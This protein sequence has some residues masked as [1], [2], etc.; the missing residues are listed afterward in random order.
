MHTCN[1]ATVCVS[2][3]LTDWE[4]SAEEMP[5]QSTLHLGCMICLWYKEKMILIEPQGF[6]QYQKTYFYSFAFY[7]FLSAVLLCKCVCFISFFID[8]WGIVQIHFNKPYTD[9]I[10]SINLGAHLFSF[11]PFPLDS[12]VTNTNHLVSVSG[13]EKTWNIFPNTLCSR[14]DLQCLWMCAW[15][16]A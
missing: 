6:K 2:L 11:W 7:W 16:S 13:V 5:I 3:N 9:D 15:P 8:L 10:F 4:G 12:D 1:T 14:R